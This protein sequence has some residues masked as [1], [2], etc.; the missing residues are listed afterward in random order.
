MLMHQALPLALAL[1][2]FGNNAG[3]GEA[4]LQ[5]TVTVEGSWPAVGIS[6]RVMSGSIHRSTPVSKDGSFLVRISAQPGA[7]LTII[8]YNATALRTNEPVYLMGYLKTTVAPGKD[9]EL[10]LTAHKIVTRDV[11]VLDQHG[12]PAANI[13]FGMDAAIPLGPGPDAPEWKRFVSLSTDEKGLLAL[14]HVES[15]RGSYHLTVNTIDAAG[16]KYQGELTLT[17]KQLMGADELPAMTVTRRQ[18]CVEARFRWDPDLGR[19]AFA[20]DV[21]A[22]IDGHMVRLAELPD[23]QALM[24]EQ[25]LARF[26]DLQPGTYTIELSEPGRRLYTI[27]RGS[28]KVTIPE[29][30]KLPVQHTVTLLP[31]GRTPVMGRVIDKST[32]KPVANAQVSATGGGGTK[33]TD[34][35]AFRLE[36]V[37]GSN[38]TLQVRHADY[39]DFEGVYP[40]TRDENGLVTLNVRLTPLPMMTVLVVDRESG[41][42]IPGCKLHAVGPVSRKNTTSKDGKCGF[43]LPEGRYELRIV[44]PAEAATVEE[45]TDQRGARALVYAGELIVP[46]EGGEVRITVPPI[47]PMRVAVKA[48]WPADRQ[49]RGPGVCLT[50]PADGT[51]MASTLL[52]AQGQ[53][54]V[55]AGEGTYR[56]VVVSDKTVGADGG[57]VEVKANAPGDQVLKI[58]VRQWRKLTLTGDA[59]MLL[60]DPIQDEPPPGK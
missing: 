47:V 7:D 57:E 55:Y 5:G 15:D 48:E 32:G 8:P 40:L 45:A 25:G 4:R 38:I 1:L 21:G 53:G 9:L 29:N 51:I 26:Y 31:A 52:D 37:P 58:E 13:D 35:G 24:N 19:R 6:L 44:R 17:G 46:K 28:E 33:T 36:D 34:D 56:V 23:R 39:Y 18:V 2:L 16:D 42:G 10:K 22:N 43:R 50:R 60:G 54:T 59:R 27:S 11:R 41:K 14:R 12:K 30:P 49:G 20:P 3:A